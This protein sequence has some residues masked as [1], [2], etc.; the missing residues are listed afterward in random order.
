VLDRAHRLGGDRGQVQPVAAGLVQVDLRQAAHGNALSYGYAV[1]WPVFAGFV[2]FVWQREFRRERGTRPDPVQPPL[3]STRPARPPG[4]DDAD[5]P[6]L[7]AYNRYLAWL[8]ANP[9]ARPA[10]YR[11]AAS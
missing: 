4:P 1:E 3:R 10:D 5:D 8:A 2:A 6:R 11:E 7:A 9:D